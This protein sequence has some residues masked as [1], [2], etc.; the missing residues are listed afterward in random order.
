MKT[1]GEYLGMSHYI[2]LPSA[3]KFPTLALKQRG[4]V[5]TSPSGLVGSGVSWGD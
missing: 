5:T 3:K 4:D 1:T 2:P